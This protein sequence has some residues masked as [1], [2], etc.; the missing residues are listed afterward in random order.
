MGGGPHVGQV[1]LIHRFIPPLSFLI[2]YIWFC[3]RSRYSFLCS[4]DYGIALC[5]LAQITLYSGGI[6]RKILV[7]IVCVL[8]LASGCTSYEDRL[9]QQAEDRW[10]KESK[11]NDAYQEGYEAAREKFSS[12]YS[13]GYDDGYEEG[14]E[15]G[16]NEAA[17]QFDSKYSSGYRHGYEDGWDHH[18][19]G[20]QYVGDEFEI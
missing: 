3:F 12:S 2:R 16:Y 20:H 8:L 10:Y 9:M 13:T 4:T 1:L 17:R 18:K 11:Y 14:Y 15:E 6:M 19:E 7:L 5:C